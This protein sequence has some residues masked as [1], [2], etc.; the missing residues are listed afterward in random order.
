MRWHIHPRNL[1]E[2]P[3]NSTFNFLKNV[4]IQNNHVPPV[5]QTPATS[6]ESSNSPAPPTQSQPQTRSSSLGNRLSLPKPPRKIKPS[7]KSLGCRNAMQLILLSFHLP[8]SMHA[9]MHIGIRVRL[10]LAATRAFFFSAY[11]CYGGLLNW[12]MQQQP[13]QQ[14]RASREPSRDRG[15]DFRVRGI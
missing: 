6:R 13:R 11:C 3:E 5:S 14:L 2:S 12:Q 9:C 7:D 1:K 15:R 8:H 10:M 4:I